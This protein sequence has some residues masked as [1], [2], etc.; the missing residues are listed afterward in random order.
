MKVDEIKKLRKDPIIASKLRE[1]LNRAVIDAQFR[2]ELF[3]A[4]EK[5]VDRFDLSRE[6]KANVLANLDSR[7]LRFIESID[8]KITL[9]SESV[10]C[11][12]GPCGIA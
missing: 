5:M 9:L 3:E 8:D 10:L 6:E 2:K 12:N 1:I 4:P 7:M 11:T